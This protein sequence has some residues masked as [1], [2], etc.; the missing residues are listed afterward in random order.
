MAVILTRPAT[1][2][3]RA[4]IVSG[5]SSSY[6]MSRDCT[7]PMEL[8]AKQ[9]HEEVEYY[10]A[11][12]KALVAHGET[13]VLFGVI[14]YDPS[15]YVATINRRQVIRDG[16]VFYVYVASPFRRRRIASH[17]FAAAGI[18]PYQRF[19]YA[20]RTQWSW[21]LRSKI[22]NAQHDSY[23]GRYYQEISNVRSTAEAGTTE[24]QRTDSG[25]ED[26]AP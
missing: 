21:D 13:G 18:N 2:A 24:E 5:W 19:G 11:R 3:D 4:F 23:R 20:C 9:K 12:A 15:T 25:S 1:T 7:T 26:L 6:R 16:F 8:Y 14:V 22:P 10:L 17:L